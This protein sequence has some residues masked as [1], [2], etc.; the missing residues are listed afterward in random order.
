MTFTMRE[1]MFLTIAI[2]SAKSIRYVW[3]K[4]H[5]CSMI[6]PLRLFAVMLARDA[7]AY[8]KLYFKVELIQV[9]LCR[10]M[11]KHCVSGSFPQ[12]PKDQ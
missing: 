4:L 1:E 12:R 5:W 6:L 7:P 3:R 11:L 9:Q 2:C 8:G 10:F